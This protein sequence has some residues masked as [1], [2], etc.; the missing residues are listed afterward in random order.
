[1]NYE[2]IEVVNLEDTLGMLRSHWEWFVGDWT[3]N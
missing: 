3:Q 2:I 1:M